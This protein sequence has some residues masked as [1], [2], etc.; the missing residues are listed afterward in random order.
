M[1][2]FK[3]I[4][5]LLQKPVVIMPLLCLL[6]IGFWIIIQ[7]QPATLA[8]DKIESEKNLLSNPTLNNS[9]NG[10]ASGWRVESSG[11]LESSYEQVA[12]T[13][14]PGALR[15]E[16][17][18]YINGSTSIYSPEVMVQATQGYFFK[19]FYTTDTKLDLLIQVKSADGT[20]KSTFIKHY[21]DYDYPLSALSTEYTAQDGDVS[22]SFVLVMSAD[23]YAEIDSA[24]VST[25]DSNSQVKSSDSLIQ[26]DALYFDKNEGTNANGERQ[27][28]T[29]IINFLSTDTSGQAGWKSNSSVAVKQH[30]LMEIGISYMSNQIAE[31]GLDYVFADGSVSYV[32]L[33]ELRPLAEMTDVSVQFEIPINAISVRPSVQLAETGITAFSNMQ[34]QLLKTADTFDSPRVSITFDD[35]W[36]S[37]YQNGANILD[38]F[39]FLGTFYINPG[40]VD[41]PGFV[42]PN[43]L[44][45]LQTR[46]HQI[47][48]HGENHIDLT[49]IDNE[50][51]EKDLNDSS[52]YVKKLGVSVMDFA[53]PYGKFDQSLTPKVSQ[54]YRSHRGTD[55]GI[56]TKQN[57][58]IYNLK[59]L[60]MRKEVSDEVL[61]KMLNQAKQTSGWVILIYHQIEPSE[62]PF[63]LDKA[64]FERQMNIVKQS[65]LQ[66]QTV[67]QAIE[68]LK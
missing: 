47:G 58:D 1:N 57:F 20:T 45:D 40:F 26:S 68:N 37:S 12:G 42:T 4:A 50:I 5:G 28:K 24:Y 22:V 8:F 15:V 23:G 39:G 2:R 35:G 59:A 7:R 51:V 48:S 60:F 16:V 17:D 19:A 56:N 34:L 41:S 30:E 55:I 63:A 33:R 53:S 31:I 32:S 14:D 64:T 21:P 38:Q 9:E 10:L 61:V 62:S 54:L 43:D 65:G 3:T 36:L 13:V 44:K 6:L 49:S 29:F 18:G 66:V 46:G 52:D 11:E 25:A 67:G 27:D